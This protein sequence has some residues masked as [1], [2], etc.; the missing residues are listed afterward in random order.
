MLHPINV[1]DPNS[2]SSWVLRR[3]LRRL[4]G[5]TLLR[6][7]R[8]PTVSLIMA[9]IQVDPLKKQSIPQLELCRAHLLAKLITQ[10]R[11][12]LLIDLD[13]TF[14]WSDSTIVLHLLDRYPMRFQMYVG[15]RLSNIL[16]NLPTR[17]WR[18]V[19]TVTN[20]AMESSH[21]RYSHTIYG[22]MDCH[23]YKWNSSN[24]LHNQCFLQTSAHPSSR[25]L[26]TWLHGH[27]P[28]GSRTDTHH[29]THS[30]RSQHGS[31]DLLPISRHERNISRYLYLSS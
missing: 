1:F 3:L 2:D 29:S 24:G 16:D 4:I 15:N 19:P 23:G 21:K 9:K 10:I 13:H 26:T 20:P 27:L 11:S 8:P 28:I 31:L 17:T 18:H 7:S 5:Q 14:A 25:I 30:A 22:G 12:S 6:G